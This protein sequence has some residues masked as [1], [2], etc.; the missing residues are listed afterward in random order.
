MAVT[1]RAV[2]DLRLAATHVR[3]ARVGA[4]GRTDLFSGR[5]NGKLEML[6]A[7]ES[8]EILPRRR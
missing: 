7:R 5:L 4:T 3:R 8:A 2:A 6:I 1:Q